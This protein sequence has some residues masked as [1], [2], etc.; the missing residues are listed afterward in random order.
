MTGAVPVSEPDV[1]P[2]PE[3]VVEPELVFV[4]DV[5]EAAVSEDGNVLPELDGTPPELDGSPAELDEPPDTA[6]PEAAS[7]DEL[8]LALPPAITPYDGAAA[9]VSGSDA[10]TVST[11]DVVEE[12]SAASAGDGAD[13]PETASWLDWPSLRESDSPETPSRDESR[14]TDCTLRAGSSPQPASM[15]AQANK[16]Y[17]VRDLSTV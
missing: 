9:S 1:V 8:P 4:D 16:R 15:A 3:T 6:A 5:P 14:P 13:T 11:E 2:P 17:E 12:S 10:V 7:V